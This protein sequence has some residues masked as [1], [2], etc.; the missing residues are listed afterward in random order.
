MRKPF[1]VVATVNSQ[2]AGKVGVSPLI[3]GEAFVLFGKDLEKCGSYQ[4]VDE[5]LSSVTGGKVE[6]VLFCFICFCI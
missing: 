5:F 1:H 6:V 4:M 2:V 3:C